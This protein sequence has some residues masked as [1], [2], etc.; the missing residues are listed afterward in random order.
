MSDNTRRELAMPCLEAKISAGTQTVGLLSASVAVEGAPTVV[1]SAAAAPQLWRPVRGPL[2][3]DNPRP[4]FG[5]CQPSRG[6]PQKRRTKTKPR[7]F[8]TDRPMKSLI[9]PYAKPKFLRSKPLTTT[10]RTWYEP[11]AIPVSRSAHPR[12][13]SIRWR[14]AQES[15]GEVSMMT[16]EDLMTKLHIR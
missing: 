1:V 8:P 13:H 10:A 9:F 16:H 11:T 5:Y 2:A 6:P 14:L 3:T 15:S 12:L 4:V 7:R